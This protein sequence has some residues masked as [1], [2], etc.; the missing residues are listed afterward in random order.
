MKKIPYIA[1]VTCTPLFLTGAGQTLAQTTLAS[2]ADIEN[3]TD[4]LACYD[5]AAESAGDLPVVRLP[6]NPR[7]EPA[8]PVADNPRRDNAAATRQDDFGL[9]LKQQRKENSGPD[10][11]SYR[12][13]AASH[14]DF[15][16]WTIEFEGG[17]KWKQVGTDDYDV[18]VGEVY[19]VRRATFNSYFLANNRNNKKIR[20]TRVE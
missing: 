13:L 11:R 16:G 9:E 3:A 19:T 4:R 7:P 12:V 10:T 2:C 18:N 5:R 1:I 17:G 14:N 8:A 15:T 6:R 20:I